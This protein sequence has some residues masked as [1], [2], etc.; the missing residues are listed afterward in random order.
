VPARR[1]AD[2]GF[3]A[4]AAALHFL[5]SFGPGMPL[6]D[7]YA[8]L[9]MATAFRGAAR[10]IWVSNFA[11]SALAAFGVEAILHRERGRAAIVASVLGGALAL[12]LIAKDGLSALDWLLAGLIIAAAAAA[13]RERLAQAAQIGLPLLIA[14]RGAVLGGPPLFDLRPGDLYGGAAPAFRFVRERLTPQDR[15]LVVSSGLDPY[16]FTPKTGSLYRVPSIFDYETQPS[17]SYAEYFTY[18]RTGRPMRSLR[19]W[20]WIFGSVLLPTL[21]RP[22][23]D[24]TAARFLIVNPAA[25]GTLA[26]FAPPLRLVH[27]DAAAQVFENPQALPRARYVPRAAVVAPGA[28][29]PDLAHGAVDPRAVALLVQPP[30]SGFLGKDGGRGSGTAEIV[31]DAAERVVVRVQASEPGFLFLADQ[32][33]PGWEASVNGRA[34]EILRA[35]HTFRLVE[36]PA[37]ASVVEFRYRP[38]SVAV[39]AVLSVLGMALLVVLYRRA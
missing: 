30:A 24:L 32:H 34:Q 15:V 35:N 27:E 28:V 10:L 4:A 3:Y 23:F 17:R 2:V 22:L 25:T 13:R 37:G 31:T 29:L 6:F 14:V 38:R 18:M 20:Y 12:Q 36:V 39:G 16:A 8:W 33:F 26:V 1:R 7:L 19:D 11:V 21:Q 5:L 9:P